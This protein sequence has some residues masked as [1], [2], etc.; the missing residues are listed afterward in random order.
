MV[1]EKKPQPNKPKEKEKKRLALSKA[2]R[3]QLASDQ[4]RLMEHRLPKEK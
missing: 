4:K 3:N 1:K 2:Y